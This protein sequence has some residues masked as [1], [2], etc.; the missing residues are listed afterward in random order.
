VKEEIP[1]NAPPTRG[2]REMI[3]IY[4]DADHAVNMVTRHSRT[5]YVQFV[6]NAVVNW[7]SKNQGS[8]ETST[9]GNEFIALKTAIEANRGL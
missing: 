6:N 1:P 5:G 3:R 2:P 9:F 8:I 7:F 4:V